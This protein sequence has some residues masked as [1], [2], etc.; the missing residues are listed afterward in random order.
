MNVKGNTLSAQWTAPFGCSEFSSICIN[1]KMYTYIDN[2]MRSQLYEAKL[3]RKMNSEDE[4]R[5]SLSLFFFSVFICICRYS[6]FD[7]L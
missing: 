4:M 7:K 2:Y 6:F 5:N 3:R 1:M